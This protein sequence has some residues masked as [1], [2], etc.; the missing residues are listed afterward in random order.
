[1]LA[2]VAEPTRL[3]DRSLTLVGGDLWNVLTT[4]QG[5]QSRADALFASIIA[6]DLQVSIA[7]RIPLREGARAHALLE[8]RGVIGKL[9]LIP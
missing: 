3:M 7:A 1:M 9:L 8:A 6:G 2:V 5:R 4:A